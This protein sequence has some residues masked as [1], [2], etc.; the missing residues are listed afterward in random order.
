MDASYEA[1]KQIMSK[2]QES[3]DMGFIHPDSPVAKATTHPSIPKPKASMAVQPKFTYNCNHC[4]QP[5]HDQHSC[6]FRDECL[7]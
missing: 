4:K 1:M 7:Q 5:G 3:S 2:Y 6:P